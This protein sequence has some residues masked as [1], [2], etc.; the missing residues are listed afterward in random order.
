[1]PALGSEPVKEIVQVQF[2]RLGYPLQ[3]PH[4]DF[5]LPVL[6]FGQMLPRQFRMVRQH[7]LCP[8]RSVRRT[9]MRLPIR[10]QMSLAIL[11]AWKTEGVLV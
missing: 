8:P 4:A 3:R 6:Q 1:M 11:Q 9:R 5:L 2:E 7:G 10:T